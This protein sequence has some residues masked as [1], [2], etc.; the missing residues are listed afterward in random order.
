[1]FVLLSVSHT[2]FNSFTWSTQVLSQIKRV[3]FSRNGYHV[4]FDANGDP[5]ATYELVNWQKSK[6]GSIELVTVG[7]YDAS[8]STGQEFIINKNL[9][10]AEGDTKV[11]Q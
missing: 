9:T 1:M 4:S 8:L 2:T 3:N 7:Q 11:W 10:W 6:S 5:V